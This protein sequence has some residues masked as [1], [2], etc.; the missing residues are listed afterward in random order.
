[1]QQGRIKEGMSA[2]RKLRQLE[3]MTPWERREL[4]HRREREK[5]ARLKWYAERMEKV[6][7]QPK[8][9]QEKACHPL[10]TDEMAAEAKRNGIARRTLRK[11]LK[12][13]WDPEEATTI[14]PKQHIPW[15]AEELGTMRQAIQ[16]KKSLAEVLNLFD[17]HPSSSVATRYYD[18]RAIMREDGLL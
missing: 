17:D 10:V 6:Q 14:P 18:E 7:E 12:N 15:T 13:G 11:R 8:D 4:R 2:E 9:Q 3:T 1:M 5:E 16:E